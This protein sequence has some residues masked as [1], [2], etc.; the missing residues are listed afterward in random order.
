MNAR[1]QKNLPLI[2]AA[3][4]ICTLCLA[5][6][7]QR[8]VPAL[9]VVEQVENLTYDWRVKKAAEYPS[10][11]S[12]NLGAVFIDDLS[13]KD[14]NEALGYEW[15][16]PRQLYGKVV[17]ELTAQGAKAI[18]FDVLFSELQAPDE[19]TNV[20]LPDGKEI[21]SDAFFA[22]ELKNSD[23]VILATFGETYTNVWQP[24]YPNDL[25]R[26]NAM[27]V[28]HATSDKDADGV[29]RRARPFKDDP[30]EG[31]RLWHMGIQIAAKELGLDLSRSIVQ[32]DRIILLGDGVQRIIPLDSEGFFYVNWSLPWND[33]DRLTQVS[34]TLLLNL[35]HLRRN[36]SMEEYRDYLKTFR[37]DKTL[38]GGDTPFKD[39][40]VVIGSIGAGN[41][42]SDIGATALEKETYLVSK[43]WNVANAVITG[44]FVRR[45]GMFTEILLIV[46]LGILSTWFTLRLP[47]P[48]PSVMVVVVGA[49]YILAAM[50]LYVGN[51]Y[52]LP[53]TL[54][55][56]GGNFLTHV[57]LVTYLVVFVEGE[58]K[59]VKAVF[60]K[61]VSPNVVNELLTA[62][63]LNLSGS[64]RHITVFFS[65]VRG[66]TQMTDTNQANAEKFVRESNLQGAAAEAYFDHS[67]Q[68]TLET[69]NLYL[70][71]IA[72]QIKLHNGTLD[73]YMGDCVMAF[74]GAPTPNEQHAVSCVQA[75]IDAQRAMHKLNVDRAEKN[76]V[77]EQ[78][79]EKRAEEGKYPLPMLPL[80]SLG[81]GINTG[82]CIVGLM[83]S[84]KHILNY[85]VFGREVN[86]ASRL[87][88]V[89]GRGRIII[90]EATFK[91]L[92]K[93]EP[94]L[95]AKCASLP[96]VM[97]KGIKDPVPIYEVP[98]RESN[99]EADQTV[100]LAKSAPAELK[101]PLQT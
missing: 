100:M 94:E 88:G 71:T 50:S 20:K 89:S 24:I 14:I 4:V 86:L 65:D 69:V 82:I 66:F 74:W 2:I 16:W 1:L 84:D 63:K 90:G 64:R 37:E 57:A 59:R 19:E 87:E 95:A 23:R 15:P 36:R 33:S 46:L 18:A 98:W 42:I 60:S 34:V 73:K 12:T 45:S 38:H 53:I 54:P 67:A 39:K 93:F 5:R 91:E 48:W 61:L 58:K 10:T 17:R 85:T 49:F 47:P 22:Q 56:I 70:A 68:D 41:N 8:D 35:D 30:A 32:D 51:R 26:T 44:D 25:F 28:S 79:N 11:T 40:L 9:Q 13:L 92:Q 52:W 83:G 101:T 29:L 97:V 55:V 99:A 75:A 77:R 78:E 62:E 7:F 76:K 43:H 96:P 80:L 81:T 21:S 31:K 3:F 6:I 27:A 72:D